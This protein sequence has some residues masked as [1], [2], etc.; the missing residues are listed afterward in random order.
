VARALHFAAGA[1]SRPLI[2][3]NCAAFNDTLLESELF[4]HERGS[5]TGADALHPGRFELASGGTLFLDE[6]GHMSLSFQ[7]KIL[8]VVEYGVYQRMGGIAELRTTARI[9]AASNCDLRQRIVE[10]AFLADLYDRLSFEV[11]EIPPL[12]QRGSDI[13]LLARHFL[14]EFARDTPDLPAKTLSAAALRALARHAFPG[15]VRELKNVIERAAYRDTRNE[16]GPADLGL[17]ADE[18]VPPS[19]TFEQRVDAYRRGLIE[20][21]MAQS[22]GNRAAAAR[23]LG[24]TYHQFRYYAK[25]YFDP[26]QA[27]ADDG[28]FVIAYLPRG[29]AQGATYK[30]DAQAKEVPGTAFACASGLYPVMNG[31]G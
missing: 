7:Q 27:L 10:G 1:A 15:N 8:R 24:L 18:P 9:V 4:G 22:G 11:L 17:A 19:G 31:P 30:P 26:T 16:I 5:F 28:S 23:Q 14:A 20:S 21:A 25:K 12:R 3:I 6:V 29:G 2:T 13:E